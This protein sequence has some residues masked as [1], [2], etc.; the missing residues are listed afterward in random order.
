MRILG[1]GILVEADCLLALAGLIGGLGLDVE[2]L[3]IAVGTMVSAGDGE[4]G[5]W[6]A[7][8][9]GQKAKAPARMDKDTAKTDHKTNPIRPS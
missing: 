1:C 4:L 5:L 7:G 9:G 6:G 3:R 8:T 2:D